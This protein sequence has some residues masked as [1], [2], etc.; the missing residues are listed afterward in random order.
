[1]AKSP[2]SRFDAQWYLTTYPDVAAAGVD[3]WQHYN[4]IGRTEGRLPY[5]PTDTTAERDLWSGFD[6]QGRPALEAQAAGPSKTDSEMARWW[7]ARWHVAQGRW[8]EADTLCQLITTPTTPPPAHLGVGAVLLAAQVAAHCGDPDRALALLTQASRTSMPAAELSLMRANIEGDGLEALNRIWQRARIG[9][10]HQIS[11]AGAILDRLQPRRRLLPPRFR[12]SVPLVSVIVPAFNAAKTLPTALASLQQQRWRA[13]DIVVVDDGSVDGTGDVAR[14]IADSDSRIRVLSSPENEGTYLARNRGMAAAQGEFLTVLD[15]DDW[16]H[17]DKIVRQVSALIGKPKRVASLSHW[18]R[19]DSN[20]TFTRWRMEPEGLVHRN[21]SSLMIRRTVLEQ[22]GFWDRVRVGAD[23]EY[24]YRLIAAYGGAALIEVLPGIPLSLGRTSTQS[25][26][27]QTETHQSTQFGGLRAEYQDASTRW[28][29]RAANQI[30]EPGKPHPLYLPRH[31]QERAFAAPEAITMGDAQANLH[32]DDVIRTAP[33]FDALWYLKDNED[34]RHATMDP[35]LHYLK[36]GAEQ[37]RDPSLRFSTS[38]YRLA[39]LGDAADTNPLIHFQ[40]T[41]AAAGLAPLPRFPGAK[42]AEKPDVLVFGHQ[43][44]ELLFGAE[45]SLLDMLDRLC[46]AGRRPLVVLPQILNQDYLTE[47]CARSTG[48]QILPYRWRHADREPD[49]ATNIAL[50]ALIAEIQPKEVHINTLVLDAPTQA[51]ARAGIDVTIH[52]RERPDQDEALCTGLGADAETIRGWILAE[53]D[54]FVANSSGVQDWIAA[55]ER[56]RL[57]PNR[58]DAALFDLPAPAGEPLCIAMISS[59]IAKKGVADFVAMA[60]HLRQM[61]H[62]VRCL[63][64]GPESEYLTELRPLPESVETAGYITDPCAAIALSDIVVSLSHFA[65]SFGRTVLEAMAA[66]RPVVCY[67]RGHPRHLIVDGI[68]GFLVP[69]DDPKAAA[70][71]IA[72][73]IADPDLRTRIGA[74]ARQRARALQSETD[75]TDPAFST[76]AALG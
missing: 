24:Y 4:K 42:A 22:L 52:V 17:P 57:V 9:R 37:G 51:A 34:V 45:R 50:D 62:P 10:M 53:A 68:S 8:S 7:L 66:A 44:G 32:P 18:V 23:T 35:A 19:C 61:K 41:G 72:K 71:T 75:Q 3:P 27:G 65:E 6:A 11:D 30:A 59:N 60:D 74:Q 48:V 15:A 28:H 29:A 14:R 31:P 69:P 67:D 26:T 39:H 1:M 33:M 58:V 43:A 12:A 16:A 38:G 25:L 76:D 54:Y 49:P 36:S 5:A 2:D 47:L 46:D 21:V 55:P 64:I 56:T 73:L 40:T 63:L 13:L 20:L 70:D